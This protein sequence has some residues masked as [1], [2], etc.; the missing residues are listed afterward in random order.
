MKSVLVSL[1]LLASASA[2]ADFLDASREVDAYQRSQQDARFTAMVPSLNAWISRTIH[3]YGSSLGGIS[4]AVQWHS[5]EYGLITAARFN[6]GRGY[7][8]AMMRG[9]ALVDGTF[10]MIVECAS[11]IEQ[12]KTFKVFHHR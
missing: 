3:Q 4:Q 5:D 2:R 12:K 1:I 9:T 10:N 7:E 11:T 8:C 6:A